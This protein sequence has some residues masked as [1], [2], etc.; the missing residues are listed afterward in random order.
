MTND[1]NI[2]NDKDIN[3]NIA[4]D[5]HFNDS[6]V[7]EVILEDMKKNRIDHMKYLPDM[8]VL[9]SDIMDR[10]VAEM[11]AY[12]YDQYT[13]ADV[14]AALSHEYRTLEDFK[15]LLSPAAQ[16]FIEEIAQA[17]QLET[18]KALRQTACACLHRFT[19]QNYCEKLLYL[20]WFQ[21]SQIKINRAKAECLRK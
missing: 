8:E 11:D 7:N 4:H 20:L 17:A 18:R 5:D 16:P 19:Y 9:D 1:T 2:T 15:A 10:V 12:D 6:I 14:R 13:A 3:A 21:L